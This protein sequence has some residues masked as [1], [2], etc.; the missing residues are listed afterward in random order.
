[1]RARVTVLFFLA[2]LLLASALALLTFS[3]ARRQLANQREDVAL[4]QAFVNASVL[5]E[6]LRNER[7]SPNQIIFQVR[8]D[9]GGFAPTHRPA[10]SSPAVDNGATISEPF[11]NQRGCVPEDARGVARPQAS[12]SG[13]PVRCDIGALELTP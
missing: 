6:L 4:R 12:S 11:Y 3:L 7:L 13:G 9:N 1:M 8:P 2:G 5:R 10:P